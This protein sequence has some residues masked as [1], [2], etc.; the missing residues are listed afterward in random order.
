MKLTN[1]YLKITFLFLILSALFSGSEIAFISANKLG[2]EV[3][4]NSGGRRGRVLASFYDNPKAFISSMLVGNNIALVIYGFFMGDLLVEWFQSLVP[5]SN[6]FVDVMLTDFS[7]LTQTIISTIVILIT[8]EFLPKVFFQIYAN[9][10]LKVLALPTYIF[11]II[12]SWVSEFIIWI[13]DA[14][15]KYSPE[16]ILA[17][18]EAEVRPLATGIGQTNRAGNGPDAVLQQVEDL[19]GGDFGDLNA[20]G[21]GHCSVAENLLAAVFGQ[22]DGN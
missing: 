13:S 12:F 20:K 15:L 19:C 16:E 1:H 3:R 14:V 6:D 2:I 7:L 8:S 4:R 9:T 22:C 10:L 18:Y 21:A 5:T 11:Y 17:A